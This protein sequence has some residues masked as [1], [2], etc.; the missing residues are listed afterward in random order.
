MKTIKVIT[1]A[2]AVMVKSLEDALEMKA[3]YGYPYSIEDDEDED[4]ENDN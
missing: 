1:P 4:D 3:M 2:G